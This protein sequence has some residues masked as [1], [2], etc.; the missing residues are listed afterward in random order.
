MDTASRSQI[1]FD[2]PLRIEDY[3][4]I[5]DC[6][7][8]A[9]VGWNGSVD[10]LCWPRFDSAACFSA[11]LGNSNH[12]RWSIAPQEPSNSSRS[13]RGDTMILGPFLQ[14]GTGPLPSWI[15]CRRIVQTRRSSALSRDNRV[16][17]ESGWSSRFVS[18]MARLCP[19]GRA[20]ARRERGHRHRRSEPCS[21]AYT[22]R[23]ERRRPF[24]QRR[25]HD[26]Q[27]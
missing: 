8:A 27:R 25:F 16:A 19:G 24:D 10:W 11:L 18:T 14:L 22:C 17:R 12:G 7:T 6:R 4:L 5:G 13:Y 9:L 23:V 2:S 20:S 21:A 26:F 15:S 3:G 1:D